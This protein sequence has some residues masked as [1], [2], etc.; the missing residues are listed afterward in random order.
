MESGSA[1][2]S[3]AALAHDTRLTVFRLLM[4]AGPDG[5]TAGRI[6]E[7]LSVPPSTLSAH[8][9]QLERAG[10]VRSHRVQRHVHYAPDIAGTRAVL[11]FL[12]EE[13]CGGRP[14][15]CGYRGGRA[16]APSTHPTSQPG[17]KAMTERTYNVLFLCTGNSARSIIAEAILN[18]EGQGRFSAYSAGS[19]PKG[20]VH[21][22]TLDLLK[23][24]NHPTEDLRSKNWDEFAGDDSPALDFVFTVCDS[25]AAETCPVWPGQPMSAHWGIPDPAAVEGTEAEKR[26][27]FAET[28]RLMT[29]R[30]SVFV[31]LPMTGL[32]KLTL[33]RRLDSI[34]GPAA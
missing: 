26:A 25:A 8:L 24:L 31:N 7:A 12:T 13:C 14:E 32:D 9:A 20:A 30:I 15:I 28:Y 18:R 21:P 27:A 16:D 4:G 1:V 34:G 10:L 2:A 5:L 3:F 17:G 6:A 33:Q 29:N 22:Y 11:A 23:K 19:Q